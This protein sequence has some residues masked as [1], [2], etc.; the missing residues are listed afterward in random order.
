[1]LGIE[2]SNRDE[3]CGDV[4]YCSAATTSSL[5]QVNLKAM[6]QSEF[7]YKKIV[8]NITG[9]KPIIEICGAPV[10]TSEFW[11]IVQLKNN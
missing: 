5:Q 7:Q 8:N 10:N 2:L 3:M 1:M 4:W 9:Y 11:Q 6:S